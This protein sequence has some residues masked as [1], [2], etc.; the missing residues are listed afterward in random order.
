MSNHAENNP[1]HYAQVCEVQVGLA[2]AGRKGGKV[3]LLGS[4]LCPEK[5]PPPLID[6]GVPSMHRTR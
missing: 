5:T 1:S 6:D 4:A 2:I 3:A